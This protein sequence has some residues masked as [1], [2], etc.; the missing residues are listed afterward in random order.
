[1][2]TFCPPPQILNIGRCRANFDAELFIELIYLIMY[3]LLLAL[4]VIIAIA[5]FYFIRKRKVSNFEEHAEMQVRVLLDRNNVDY[6]KQYG[7]VIFQLNIL[8][9]QLKEVV[10]TEIRTTNRNFLINNFEKL[11]FFISPS[12]IG[13]S[14]MRSI[15]FSIY[16]NYLKKYQPKKEGL[17]VKGYIKDVKNVKKAFMQT[18]YFKMEPLG[19]E[20]EQETFHG[21]TSSLAI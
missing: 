4:V 8:D 15:G 11:N 2:S 1:M 20:I 5:S 14:A 9:D 12:H 7:C 10:I 21:N 18:S 16:N 3:Y 13:E 19:K 6:V 17:I